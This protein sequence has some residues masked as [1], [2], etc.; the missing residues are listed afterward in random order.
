MMQVMHTPNA[1]AAVFQPSPQQ[2]VFFDWIINGIGSCILEAVAGAGKTSTLIHGLS[3]MNGSIFFGA[4]NKKIA[5]EIQARAPQ[6]QGLFISTM[7]AAGFKA[8]RR[9]APKVQVDGYKCRE[10]FRAACERNPEAGYKNFEGPVLQLVSLAKQAGVGLTKRAEDFNVWMDLVEHF[11]VEVYDE[12]TGVD[13]SRLIIQLARK[14]LARSIERDTEVVD[15]DDM[16]YAPLVHNVRMFEHDWVLIDEAQDTNETRRLLALRM[17]KRGGRLV[18]VGDRHQAIY[19]FT[20][21]DADSLDLIAKAVN[22]KQLPLTTTFRCPKSV[23]TYAQQ[24]VNHIQAADSA[25]DGTVKTDTIENLSNV[26]TPGDAILCRFNAPL[27]EYVYKFIAAGIPAKVEGREIGNGLKVL[28]RRWKVKK[29]TALL[30]KLATYSE[31]ESAKYRVKEQ[32]AKAAAVEDKVNCL[33]TIVNRVLAIDPDCANPVDRV[34]QEIDAI[35]TEEGDAKA[36]LFSSIHKSKGREWN[37]VVW[38]QSG[39]SAWARQAWEVE[40][41]NNLCY[42]AATRAKSELVLIEL[43]KKESK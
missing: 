18:A 19:G 43:P 15:F 26:A 22:A 36:V 8:W 5:E 14:T 38:L 40:Q 11:D 30:D 28:A 24:W 21:A 42:V 13:N 12:D 29:L 17:L 4:Y 10:I 35:F 7:H 27:L 9:A 39:P 25:P 2:S 41:E 16:I 32:E 3:L 37:R 6:R 33:V 31:R 23:V 34:C 1:I 20:G